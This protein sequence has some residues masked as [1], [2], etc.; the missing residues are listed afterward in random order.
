MSLSLFFI[1]KSQGYDLKKGSYFR[2]KLFWGTPKIGENTNLLPEIAPHLCGVHVQ[3]IV[4]SL[5]I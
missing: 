2:Q 4:S 3:I 1:G 5:K